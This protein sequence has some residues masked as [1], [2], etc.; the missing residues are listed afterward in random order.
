MRCYKTFSQ[1]KSLLPTFGPL[2]LPKC[3]QKPC[4]GAGETLGNHFKWS[5]L[6]HHTPHQLCAISFAEANWELPDKDK[7][8][9]HWQWKKKKGGI[10]LIN[11]W[12]VRLRLR[13]KG[14]GQMALTK[15]KNKAQDVLFWRD[16]VAVLYTGYESLEL[17]ATKALAVSFP[18]RK[19]W[20]LE[21]R[22]MSLVETK[23][24][25]P[26]MRFGKISGVRTS[27]E[28]VTIF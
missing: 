2:L 4:K 28:S 9:C 25:P 19:T 24:F 5:M 23:Y 13:W 1:D 18:G 26:G 22:R 27:W 12:G 10:S 14:I 8:N 20:P 17:S 3:L 6:P 15:R 11:V 16:D 7:S 21:R